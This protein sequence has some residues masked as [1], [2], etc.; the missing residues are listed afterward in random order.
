M[1]AENRVRWTPVA[2]VPC[3]LLVVLIGTLVARADE[4]GARW[5]YLQQN[6]Q[7]TENLPQI[8]TVLRRAGKAGYNGVVLADYKLNILDRVPDHYFQ[9][10][11]R[12]RKICRE[13]QLEI[14]PAVCR[15]GYSSGILAHDPNLAEA[16]PVQQTPFVVRGDRVLPEGAAALLDGPF[17]ERRGHAFAGWSFQDDPGSG[18]F[19]DETVRHG[20]QASLRIENPPGVRAN[21]RV[22]KLV[23]VRP[24]SQYHAS[25]WI[26]TADF[27]SASDTRMSAMSPAG[28][29]LS[30]S[31]LGVRRDQDWTQHHIIFNS[32]DNSEVRFY[33]GAWDCGGGKMWLDDVR[34]VEEPLVNLVRRPGCPLL[35]RDADGQASYE[36]GRDF[37]PLRDARLGVTPWPGE[38]DVYHEPPV[39]RLLPGSRIR[40]G[41]HLQ[42]SFY[43]AVTIYDGQVPCSLSE[44]KTFEIIEDQVRRVAKLFQPKMYF[45]SH[46]EIR[47][48]GWS[49]P[50]RQAGLTAGQQLAANVRR[51]VQIIRRIQ[52]DARLC[53]WSDMFDPSHN[54]VQDFYLVNGD[55]AGSWEGLSPDM[56]VVNW[57]SGKP[58]QSLPF[59]A[60]RGHPQVLAGYYDGPPERIRDWLAAGR[61]LKD[62]PGVMYTTWRGDFSQLEAFAEH[63]W[64]QPRAAVR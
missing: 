50:E 45:L 2:S 48:A 23:K 41:Q 8:E 31:N 10:A 14:I 44:P 35:V 61:G 58:E 17:E 49:E 52:P 5:V 60:G 12:F 27:E 7:V 59:F 57:N 51:C 9:N 37:A 20:G 4:P 32:L 33:L 64:G 30:H 40:D 24:W 55:L 22:S 28:R 18:T 53:I 21:R 25:A 3:G 46:D 6:L 47:V 54:A 56:T 15:F 63:A 1:T 38:F 43:H 19:A 36:E 34:L 29:V 13:L 16:L 42:V 39:L 62:P 26:R 11:A